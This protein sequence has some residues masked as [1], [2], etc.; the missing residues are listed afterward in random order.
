MGSKR[1]AILDVLAANLE[2]GEQVVHKWIL[3]GCHG[4]HHVTGT[5]DQQLEALLVAH[6]QHC[7][8]YLGWYAQSLRLSD[9]IGATLE[10]SQRIG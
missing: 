2:G 5:P 9:R 7:R 1:D 3:V 10:R 6:A 4:D 8:D